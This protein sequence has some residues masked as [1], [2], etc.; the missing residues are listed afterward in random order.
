MPVV[1]LAFFGRLLVSVTRAAV[2]FGTVTVAAFFSAF[3][4]GMFSA[5]VLVQTFC[6]LPGMAF[7]GDTE[8]GNCG[9]EQGGSFHTGSNLAAFLRL[10]N[11]HFP[12]LG[13]L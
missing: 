7:T 3:F 8:E 11:F 2:G 5:A 13:F 4:S 1:V 6:L 9:E 12:N 10:F